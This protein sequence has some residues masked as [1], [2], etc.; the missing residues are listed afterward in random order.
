MLVGFFKEL[1]AG[2]MLLIFMT[3]I[4]GI[5]YPALITTL[6]GNFFPWRSDGSMLEQNN[7]IIG[8]MFIGQSFT[9]PKYFW[10]RP[11]ATLPFPYNAESSSGS[12]LGPMNPD[13]I[14]E[15]KARKTA[16]ENSDTQ[17]NLAVPID[18]VTASASGLDPE[19]S[20]QAAFYQVYRIAKA[21]KIPADMVENLLRKF[22][23]QPSFG[24]L[25]ETRVNVLKLNLALDEL[26]KQI[27]KY[28]A[29]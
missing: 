6:A 3:I 19:I 18:M 15:L 24:L 5:A 16:L 26:D 20:P 2:I 29:P 21:R 12:N 1:R 25:G 27:P 13:Y 8:S 17:N 10:G 7:K 28:K 11:S 23:Q 9:N 22:I 4:T 14:A